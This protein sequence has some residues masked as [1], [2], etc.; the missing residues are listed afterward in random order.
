MNNRILF[1]NS[2]SCLC[3]CIAKHQEEISALH[4][5]NQSVAAGLWSIW[6]GYILLPTIFDTC[7]SLYFVPVATFSEQICYTVPVPSSYSL[8][9]SSI[10]LG[11]ASVLTLS[12]IYNRQ[13]KRKATHSPLRSSASFRPTFSAEIRGTFGGFICFYYHSFLSSLMLLNIKRAKFIYV[14]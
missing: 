9:R 11:N 6:C 10:T 8:A 1:H 12:K 7:I 5:I 14:G 3:L 2:I 4:K 13:V